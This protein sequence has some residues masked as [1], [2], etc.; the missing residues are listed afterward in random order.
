[1]LKVIRTDSSNTDFIQLV[2]FLDVELAELDGADHAYYAQFNKIEKIGHVVLCYQDGTPVAC[3]AIKEFDNSSMEIKRMYTV[4]NMRGRGIATKV[5]G[6]LET[7]ASEMSCT[8][9]VLETGKRQPDAVD[10]YKKNGYTQIPNYGQYTGM[11]N[12]VCFEKTLTGAKQAG[13]LV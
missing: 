4:P 12:S 2:R 11:E 1:M 9:C 3:G 8:R 6:E 7:W 13:Q 10:L 5:L